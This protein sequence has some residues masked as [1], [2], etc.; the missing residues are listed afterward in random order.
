[1]TRAA[2]AEHDRFDERRPSEVVD[3][4]QRRPRADQRPDDLRVPQV[5]GGDQRGTVVA[6]G[7]VFRAR[8]Q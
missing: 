6:A 1:M 4:V 7:D 8:A 5:R 2:I 3:V